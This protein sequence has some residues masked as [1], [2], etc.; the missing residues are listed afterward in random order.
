MEN[1]AWQ[2]DQNPSAIC[3]NKFPSV[4]WV[5]LSAESDKNKEEEEEEEGA[6][7]KVLTETM[8]SDNPFEQWQGLTW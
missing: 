5:W 4:Q 3:N 8:D 7:K 6:H 1:T 2:Q